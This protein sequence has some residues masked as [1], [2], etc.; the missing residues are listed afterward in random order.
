MEFCL[1]GKTAKTNIYDGFLI[2][3]Y[4]SSVPLFH[5][6]SS[7]AFHIVFKLLSLCLPRGWRWGAGGGGWL[8]GWFGREF[9]EGI[10]KFFLKK[11]EG[12]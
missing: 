2:F 9:W 12:V 3:C 1:R 7:K 4:F 8:E 10:W 5:S 11:K 6:Y